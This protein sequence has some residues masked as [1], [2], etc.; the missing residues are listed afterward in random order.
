MRYILKFFLLTLTLFIAS[1]PVFPAHAQNWWSWEAFYIE[2]KLQAALVTDI[3]G[4]KEKLPPL[5]GDL[6][7]IPPHSLYSPDNYE[8]DQ[9]WGVSKRDQLELV[10]SQ[11]P[12]RSLWIHYSQIKTAIF[13]KVEDGMGISVA[14]DNGEILKG[15]VSKEMVGFKGS[16]ALGELTY[17][18]ENIGSIEF[19]EFQAKD[20]K[21]KAI[22]LNRQAFSSIWQK[23][24]EK[25]RLKCECMILDGST[26]INA[27]S[28]HIKDTAWTNQVGAFIYSKPVF[29]ES[30]RLENVVVSKG[31]AQ[32]EVRLA[33]LKSLEISGKLIN[34]NPE[35]IFVKKDGTTFSGGLLMAKQWRFKEDSTEYGVID[36]EDMLIYV[37]P[38][39]WES[40]SLIPIRQIVLKFSGACNE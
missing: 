24:H 17:K 13:D 26:I 6:S 5:K 4:A 31:A 7:P 14:L 34:N 20:S 1:F 40:I 36:E 33:D 32:I 12:K 8:D 23:Q 10:L 35:V 29:R 19:L 25:V 11:T 2:G 39:G 37:K 38:Y 30:L 28:F 16:S 9:V 15:M 3:T 21:D 22:I 27:K 18:I